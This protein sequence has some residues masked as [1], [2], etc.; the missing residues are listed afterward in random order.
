ML[1]GAKRHLSNPGQIILLT[2]VLLLL[3]ACGGG[4]PTPANPTEQAATA[5]A[6]IEATRLART[7]EPEPTGESDGTPVPGED[8]FPPLTPRET[9]PPKSLPY[10]PELEVEP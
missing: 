8:E 10:P 7:A 5:E 6:V 9:S 3:A 4:T 1:N 2:I